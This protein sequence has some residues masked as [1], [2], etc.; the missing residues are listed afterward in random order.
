MKNIIEKESG[1]NVM[2]SKKWKKLKKNPKAFF[3]DS[4][5]NVFNLLKKQQLNRASIHN[6]NNKNLEHSTHAVINHPSSKNQIN[7]NQTFLASNEETILKPLLETFDFEYLIKQLNQFDVTAVYIKPINENFKPALCILSQQK[8]EFLRK[9]LSF[10]YHENITFKYKINHKLKTPNSINEFW[11]DLKTVQYI[12]IR[13]ST[14]RIVGDK[15]NYFWFRL[16][17]C[18]EETD[19]IMFPTNNLVSRKLWKHTAEQY[20]L[21]Q[22][23]IQNY[24]NILTYSHEQ[25]INFDIDLVFTWVNSDDSDWQALYHQYKPNTDSDANSKS[26]FYSRD[27]LKYA[28]RSWEKYGSFIRKIFIVSNCREP[29]WLDKNHPKIEWIPHESIIPASALPTFSSHAIEACL[30]KIPG[31]SNHFI[32]SNDDI[33][34]VKPLTP[35]VFF[36]HNGIAKLRMEPYGNVNGEVTKGEPDYLNAARNGTRLLEKEFG[37]T[38]TQLHTH[39]PQS[40]RV[41]VLSEMNE[42]YKEHFDKT[43]HNKFRNIHDISVTSYFYQH[44]ALLSGKALLANEKTEIVIERHDYKAKLNLI[45]SKSIDKDYTS[46]PISVCLNDGAQ[47]YL[48]EQWNLEIIRF[49]ETFLPDPA[50]FEI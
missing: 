1:S 46:M 10:A 47:S 4:R 2:N 7:I 35:Y 6:P 49:L 18:L 37:Q 20:K 34:L 36:H 28:L 3:R 30:H 16:E 9:F 48:N 43:I 5:L 12:D 22:S 38:P 41:D 39:S 50:S 32:Y 31:L 25:K 21:F 44:Y 33:L 40:M 45:Q 11:K 8:E 14:T 42:K 27:E 19:F 26:R 13:L 23:G 24:A 29:E 17:F 15:N